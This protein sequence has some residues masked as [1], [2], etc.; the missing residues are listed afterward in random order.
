MNATNSVTNPRAIVPQTK[1]VKGSGKMKIK[2]PAR[3]IE[4]IELQ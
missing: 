1:K 2:L 4:V 3:S